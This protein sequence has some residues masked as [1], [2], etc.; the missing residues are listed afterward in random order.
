MFIQWT[1]LDRRAKTISFNLLIINKLRVIA[2][3]SL[4]R[5]IGKA[6]ATQANQYA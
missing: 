5:P 3:N 6:T 1:G 4:S 2:R